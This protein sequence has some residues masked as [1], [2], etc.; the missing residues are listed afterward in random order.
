MS[1]AAVEVNPHEPY[2][3]ALRGSGFGS[4]DL[5]VWIECECGWIG[6]GRHTEDRARDDHAFHVHLVTTWPNGEGLEV[7]RLRTKSWVLVDLATGE[8]ASPK[9]PHSW[10][11]K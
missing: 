3:Q 7:K 5:G 4:I 11:D 2:E 8:H 6:P 9:P 10:P 1:G